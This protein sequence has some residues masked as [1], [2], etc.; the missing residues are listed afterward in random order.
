VQVLF[1]AVEPHVN[2]VAAAVFRES[3]MK[4]LVDV[5]DQVGNKS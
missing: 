1:S 5:A 4:G 2:T 3:G